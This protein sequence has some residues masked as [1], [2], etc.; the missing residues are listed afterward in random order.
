MPTPGRTGK[1][2]NHLTSTLY[3]ESDGAQLRDQRNLEIQKRR[4]SAK[5]KDNYTNIVHKTLESTPDRYSRNGTNRGYLD[6]SENSFG[7]NNKV[8]ATSCST[9][10]LHLRQQPKSIK[11]I[12]SVNELQFNYTASVQKDTVK[13]P[14][15]QVDYL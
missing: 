12:E 1:R 11:S 8:V 2:R 6:L 9:K 13:T 10:A 5:L 4:T 3:E 7:S 14:N 15:A